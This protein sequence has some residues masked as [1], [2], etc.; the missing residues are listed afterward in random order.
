MITQQRPQ[1]SLPGSERCAMG[2]GTGLCVLPMLLTLALATLATAGPITY[3]ITDLERMGGASTGYGS[4]NNSGQIVG[5]NERFGDLY[6]HS[7]LYTPGT[8]WTDLGGL[9]G[10]NS[11]SVAVNNAGWVA[12]YAEMSYGGWDA[13]VY[14]PGGSLTDLGPGAGLG[15]PMD[16]NDAG[17]VVGLI[18]AYYTPSGGISSL[19]SLGPTFNTP[20][21]QAVNNL[22]QIAGV[23]YD[24]ASAQWHLFLYDPTSGMT[25]LGVPLGGSYFEVK[26]INDAGVIV[27]HAY[28]DG[29][30]YRAFR[31]SPGGGFA[32]LGALPGAMCCLGGMN[33]AGAVV[34]TSAD[35]GPGA[36]LFRPGI[37]VVDLNTL[38]SPASGWTLRTALGINDQGQ[39]VGN[40][41]Y[42][43]DTHAYLLTPTPEPS[44]Y[45]LLGA[46]LLSLLVLR[47]CLS[48][49]RGQPRCTTSPGVAVATPSPLTN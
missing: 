45:L 49:G 41:W 5:F 22:G 16:I 37:G 21:G 11:V 31:Y 13:Y 15:Q 42:A 2:A 1:R 30:G 27:G 3:T 12:G 39:I 26:G 40:G 47:R 10:L 18:G 17:M 48:R 4:I 25:D 28:V 35:G 32:D 33:E 43:E 36:V 29:S 20:I 34:G 23:T 8:G 6:F 7:Y 9:G 44:S 14:Q 19:P 24:S 38:I 46:G